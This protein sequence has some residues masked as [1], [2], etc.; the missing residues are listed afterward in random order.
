MQRRIWFGVVLLAGVVLGTWPAL[1][2][3]QPP[4]FGGG[5]IAYDPEPAIVRSAST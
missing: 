3:L 5:V 1:G 2:Q 4:F